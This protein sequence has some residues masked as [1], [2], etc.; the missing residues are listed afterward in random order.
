MSDIRV[1]VASGLLGA[2]LTQCLVWI[3]EAAHL[4]RS[5]HYSA[6]RLALMCEHYAVDCASDIENRTGPLEEAEPILPAGMK[7]PILPDVPGDIDFRALP[8]ALVEPVLSLR[9]EVG[10]SESALSYA[11]DHLDGEELAEEYL[12]VVASRGLQAWKLGEQIRKRTGLSKAALSVGEWD[13]LSL[14][15]QYALKS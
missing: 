13:F 8:A 6:L 5:R 7:L 10:F 3:R 4:R 12:R 1:A 2:G 15:R 11:A 9:V 14:L